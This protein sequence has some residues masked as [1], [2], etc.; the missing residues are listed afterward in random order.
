M[1]KVIKLDSDGDLA[2]IGGKL[3]TT[4][5]LGEYVAQRH[6]TRLRFVYGEWFMN[7]LAGIPWFEVVLVKNPDLPLIS[8]I[9]QRV[10]SGTR[11][12][13]TVTSLSL[14]PDFKTRTAAL[15]YTASLSDGTVLRP[16]SEMVF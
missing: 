16:N 12:V 1:P 2:M 5:T 7:L 13:Q 6:R 11:G 10:L 3:Q 4:S 15:T 9:V 8:A 14:I